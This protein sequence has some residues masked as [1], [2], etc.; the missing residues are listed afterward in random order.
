MDGNMKREKTW[1]S[2]VL[3]VMLA[4]GIMILIGVIVYAFLQP[5][6]FETVMKMAFVIVVALIAI[7]L[8]VYAV[9]ALASIPM[10]AYKGESYQTDKSYSLDQI[11]PVKEK[12]LDD[13]TK[14]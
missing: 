4:I 10:Y 6:V 3:L 2:A 12:G 14:H 13:D 11:E 8:I 5:G 9:I 1:P 7:A